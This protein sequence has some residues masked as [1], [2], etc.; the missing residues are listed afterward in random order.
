MRL[1]D[2]DGMLLGNLSGVLS[3]P[4]LE[5]LESLDH[6]VL[7]CRKR[8]EANGRMLVILKQLVRLVY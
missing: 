6:I 1:R 7:L 3:P 8:E 5:G 2:Y 4:L